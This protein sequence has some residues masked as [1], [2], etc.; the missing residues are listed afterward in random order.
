MS[1]VAPPQLHT[2]KTHS[3]YFNLILFPVQ[4]VMSR[5]F[6]RH[7]SIKNIPET[8]STAELPSR[9]FRSSLPAL[10]SAGVKLRNMSATDFHLAL[11]TTSV[12]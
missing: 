1:Q 12:T 2:E 4:E 6:S 8:G 5:M 7:Y 3:T 10:R 11:M 9:D